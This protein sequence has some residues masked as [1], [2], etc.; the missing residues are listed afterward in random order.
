MKLNPGLDEVIDAFLSQQKYIGV[1]EP[2][3]KK[4][5]S[6]VF[7]PIFTGVKAVGSAAIQMPD[8]VFKMGLEINKAA[9]NVIRVGS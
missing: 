2:L 8:Q 5:A 4:I 7:D 9:V 3:P 1:S 6:A